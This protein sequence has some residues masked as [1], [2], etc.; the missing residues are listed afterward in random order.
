MGHIAYLVGWVNFNV[1]C[2]VLV[3]GT[4]FRLEVRV[5]HYLVPSD[6]VGLSVL[7]S[8]YALCGLLTLLERRNYHLITSPIQFYFWMLH[9]VCSIPAFVKVL[10]Y[11]V[12]NGIQTEDL[13]FAITSTPFILVSLVVHSISEYVPGSGDGS[14]DTTPPEEKSSHCSFI[15]FSF[16]DS[17][18]WKG[19]SRPLLL[20]ELPSNPRSVN[21]QANVERFLA[22]W[23]AAIDDKGVSM[24]NPNGK[25]VGIWTVLI[26]TYGRRMLVCVALA[27]LFTIIS[28]ANPLLL[29]ALITYVQ[30]DGNG[31]QRPWKG[32]FY[33]MVL[34]LCNL[35]KTVSDHLSLHHLIVVGQQM[36]SSIVSAIYQ[37]SLKI[38]N[39]AR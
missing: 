20:S 21:V 39:K 1:C 13:I 33:I 34:F 10:E 14:D 11:L 15:L 29:D 3:S 30:N 5:E 24:I 22:G 28:F 19:F 32:Y 8:T 25:S 6:V 18:I 4:I 9:F 23:N 17:L 38:S 12:S 37:K 36:R 16:M 2:R 27:T 7:L 26:K 35:V 31:D